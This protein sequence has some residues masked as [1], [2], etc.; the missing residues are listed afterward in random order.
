MRL[1]F[2]WRWWLVTVLSVAL[3][4]TGCSS[5]S[6]HTLLTVF[7]TGVDPVAPVQVT[8]SNS[9]VAGALVQ[10]AVHAP[11]QTETLHKPFMERKCSA[12]HID[13]QSEQLRASGRELCWD[14]HRKLL[15]TAKIV[16]PLV[17][18]GKCDQCHA[19]HKSTE[20]YLLLRP[21]QSLCLGCHASATMEQVKGHA[22]MGT[23]AC[24]GC[25]DPH[26]SD[27]AKL[28]KAAP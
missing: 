27:R 18:K 3:V 20:H 2:T 10:P 28:L 21:A 26:R 12:C 5:Q 4:V 14:C 16:H 6:R 23:E 11:Q 13:N 24:L 15:D 22:T 7:F 25:H 8:S 9:P 1:A 19:A 17:A